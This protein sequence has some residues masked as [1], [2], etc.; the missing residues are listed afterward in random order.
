[1]GFQ[2]DSDVSTTQC[3]LSVQRLTAMQRQQSLLTPLWKRSAFLPPCSRRHRSF[4][5]HFV[6]VSHFQQTAPSRLW[7]TRSAA[8]CMREPARGR[9]LAPSCRALHAASLRNPR[10]CFLRS[11]FLSFR[12]E[13]VWFTIW[14]G[15]KTLPDE[16]CGWVWVFNWQRRWTT[17]CSL[18]PYHWLKQQAPYNA[19]CGALLTTSGYLG[20]KDHPEAELPGDPTVKTTGL[21]PP[22][23][24]HGSR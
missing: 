7:V 22:E 1:M 3:S 19:T 15:G 21:D 9:A 5:I 12:A 16:C 11:D 6:E 13:W 4:S 2:S 18:F 14:R 10:L 20:R 24:L 17:T 8:W 23:L